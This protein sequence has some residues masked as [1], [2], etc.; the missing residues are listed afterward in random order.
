MPSSRPRPDPERPTFFIDRGLGKHHVPA[1][2]VGAGF[3][4]I[5]MA[6]VYDD[7]GQFVADD[8]WIERASS[9][10][11][12]ALTKDTAIVRD[13]RDALEASTLRVFALPSANLTGPQMAERFQDNLDRVVRRA[14]RAGPYVDVIHPDRL[15][16]SVAPACEGRRLIRL[17]HVLNLVRR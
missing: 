16:R 15:E 5:R 14:Q 4:V 1:V 9:E 10:G 12:V 8:D 7:D 17:G 3:D 6:D 13:H 2:F 11:W